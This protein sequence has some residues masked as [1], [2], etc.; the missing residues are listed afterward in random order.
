LTPR[1]ASPEEYEGDDDLGL[2]AVPKPPPH[3]HTRTS[4]AASDSMRGKADRQREAVYALIHSKP[5]GITREEIQ[6][7]LGLDGNSVRPRV[8]EL[9]G[10]G[11]HPAR[12]RETGEVRRG[13][14]GRWMEVLGDF[15]VDAPGSSR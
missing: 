9:L 12:I 5:L 13:R 8:W 7:S 15:S 2:F 10:N 6:E 1:R 14:S 4:I 11:G 3:N